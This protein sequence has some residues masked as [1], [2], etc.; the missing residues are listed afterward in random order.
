ME[1]LA[2]SDFDPSEFMK[3][4]HA[5]LK[6]NKNI[7]VVRQK[8]EHDLKVKVKTKFIRKQSTKMIKSIFTEKWEKK[9][10]QKL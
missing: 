8:E 3:I 4:K 7:N 9:R 2:T 10:D 5:L 1:F 6:V